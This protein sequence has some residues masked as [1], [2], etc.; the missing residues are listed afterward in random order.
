VV[1]LTNSNPGMAYW[2]AVKHAFRYL[3][4]TLNMKLEY[5][6]DEDTEELFVTFCDAD[7][8]GNPDNRKSTSGV[9]VKV[10][11]GAVIWISKLQSIVMLSTT[12]AEHMAGV[13]GG[14]EICWL[15]NMMLELGY[16]VIGPLQLWMDNQSSM[17]VER[18]LNIMGR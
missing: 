16:K 14:K 9:L 1:A 12:E 10:G 3:K 7:H 4:S 8:G 17:S 2:K 6:P 18:I 13:V 15:R 11:R 5:G